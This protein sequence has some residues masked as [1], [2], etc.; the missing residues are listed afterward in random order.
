MAA[1]L[2]KIAPAER[3]QSRIHKLEVETLAHVQFK[4]ITSDIQELVASSGVQNGLCQIFVMHTTA[5]ILIN[6]N[7]DPA[8]TKDL[9]DFL[10]RLAPPDKAY[11]HNDGN[12]DSHLKASL[13]GCTKTLL[14]ENG[15]PV[16]GRWQGIYL[17]E[18]DGPRRRE[19]RIKI[20]A[21]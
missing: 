13:I 7:D 8:F 17:C 21:D 1:Q 2:G 4:D 9:D 12:C 10:V 15:R 6:E 3:P 14:V 18:F 11:H 20:V 19:L 16:L 5:A